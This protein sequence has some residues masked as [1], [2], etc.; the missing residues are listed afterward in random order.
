VVP[1][2]ETV[3]QVFVY[4]LFAAASPLALTSTI[5]VLKSDRARLNGLSFASAFL[6]G[7]SLVWSCALV[8]GSFTLNEGDRSAS[9]LKL[10][11]GLLLLLAA[12]RVHSGFVPQSGPRSERAERLLARLARLTPAMTFWAGVL[13]GIGGPKRLTITL[14]AAATVSVAGLSR[15]DE[16]ALVTAYILV[17]GVLV[18]LPVAVYVVAGTRASGWLAAAQEWLTARQHQI[19]V[20]SLLV[21]GTLLVVDA[22][23]AFL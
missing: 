9:I 2:V 23:V 19:S 8:L 4:A 16:L 20:Y 21:I 13:L 1:P 10:V 14:V 17:A 6:L 11:V 22:L 7:E 18:W 12:W 3:L 5:V 15:S